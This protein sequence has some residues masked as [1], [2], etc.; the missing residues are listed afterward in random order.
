MANTRQS[1]ACVCTRSK[2]MELCKLWK[3]SSSCMPSI[4]SGNMHGHLC[5]LYAWPQTQQIPG[6]RRKHLHGR[7]Q[8]RGAHEHGQVSWCNSLCAS[9]GGEVGPLRGLV[10]TRRCVNGHAHVV[11]AGLGRL[12][13]HLPCRRVCES[14]RSTARQKANARV[15]W[16]AVRVVAKQRWRSQGCLHGW[17]YIV[18]ECTAC[19][20]AKCSIRILHELSSWPVLHGRGAWRSQMQ[21]MVCAVDTNFPSMYSLVNVS[22]PRSAAVT[23]SM[24]DGMVV[25]TAW[26]QK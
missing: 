1:Y 5:R 8:P 7:L 23:P 3:Q 19:T 17:A 24:A 20:R 22:T 16:Q 10:G 18:H 15:S 9:R 6:A 13:E 11:G 2:C 21:S 4:S 12:V 26:G 25:S 14:R